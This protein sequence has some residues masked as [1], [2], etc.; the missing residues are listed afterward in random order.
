[1]EDRRANAS[2]ATAGKSKEGPR[3][4]RPASE[5]GI[6]AGAHL[7]LG[8]DRPKATS[9]RVERHM[10]DSARPESQT[11]QCAPRFEV[12][13]RNGASA[14]FIAR[15]QAGSNGVSA[16]RAALA[17]VGLAAGGWPAVDGRRRP[18]VPH[19]RVGQR[20]QEPDVLA[21]Q[22]QR[23]IGQEG[24]QATP[25]DGTAAT[26][27]DEGH[28]AD[29]EAHGRRE[30]RDAAGGEGDDLVTTLSRKCRKVV[31]DEVLGEHGHRSG[32]RGRGRTARD[33][34]PRRW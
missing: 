5:T 6:R 30:G 27:D 18:R 15:S 33:H 4:A 12:D 31:A 21:A 10:R 3:G 2:R 1:M 29:T 14:P 26:V 34:G 22:R 8:A 23:V 17:R 25:A 20:A 16:R 9:G 32:S 24:G 13:R 11:R 28:D 19:V 7:D